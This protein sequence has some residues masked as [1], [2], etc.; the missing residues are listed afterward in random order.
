ME[1]YIQKNLRH[2]SKLVLSLSWSR[3]L[4]SSL[5]KVGPDNGRTFFCIFV[6]GRLCMNCDLYSVKDSMEV[7][8]SLQYR[9]GRNLTHRNTWEK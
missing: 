1:L 7:S 2:I 5:H 6:D 8:L 4:N 9:R 3:R